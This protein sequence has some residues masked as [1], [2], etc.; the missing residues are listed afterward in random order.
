MGHAK[1]SKKR[2]RNAQDNIANNKTRNGTSTALTPP[3]SSGSEAPTNLQSVLSEEEMEITV[4][5]LLTLAKFPT[6]IKSKQCRSLRTAVYDFR[7]AC[8]TGVNT[9]GELLPH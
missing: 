1:A 6:I 8:T 7:Q 2:K 4:D 5:T 9:S 3:D